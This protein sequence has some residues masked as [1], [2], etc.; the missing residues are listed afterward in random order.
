MLYTFYTL[1]STDFPISYIRVL[2]YKNWDTAQSWDK[3]L[4]NVSDGT[5]LQKNWK[6]VLDEAA[7]QGSCCSVISESHLVIK[8]RSHAFNAP[9][10]NDCMTFNMNWK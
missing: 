2:M 8:D 9:G 6:Y 1:K 7:G 10:A 5:R 4:N 3:G